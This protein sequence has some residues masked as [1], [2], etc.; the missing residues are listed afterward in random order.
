LRKENNIMKVLMD[1]IW[2]I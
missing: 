1:D 2:R